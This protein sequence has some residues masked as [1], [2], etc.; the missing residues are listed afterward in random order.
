[1][2]GNIEKKNIIAHFVKDLSRLIQGHAQLLGLDKSATDTLIDM[3]QDDIVDHTKR[4]VF[5]LLKSSI[6]L[7]ESDSDS[8][9]DSDVS[10]SGTDG[11]A[12]SEN[13]DES[14]TDMSSDKKEK[15]QPAA[16]SKKT[17]TSR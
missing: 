11:D 2:S 3:D 12:E 13:G 17:T 4:F 9:S 10:E 14:D 15:K 8:G 7:E 6:E 16:A 5:G 1:M